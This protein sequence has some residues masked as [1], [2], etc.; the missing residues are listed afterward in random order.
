MI[1]EKTLM[2][3]LMLSHYYNLT[4][5]IVKGFG[6]H[7][8]LS[9]IDNTL[10]TYDDAKPT[11]EVKQ[12][13]KL[14]NENGIQVAFVSNNDWERVTLFCEGMDV[15]FFAK[16]GKPKTKYL[17]LACEKLGVKR[18][19]TMLL[20]D[21]LLTDCAS[22]KCFGIPAVIVPPIKDRTSAFFRFKRWIEKP[23][24]KKYKKLHEAKNEK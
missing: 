16:A 7:I 23:Y 1:F 6:A 2:P 10:V 8:I 22:A 17:A 11:E 13:L 21:Q 15:V 14:M 20:G 9:D 19:E 18:E 3:D 5:E 12:W 24:V 4:P